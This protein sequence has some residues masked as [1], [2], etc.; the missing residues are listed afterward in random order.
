MVAMFHLETIGAAIFLTERGAE[1]Q[2]IMMETTA[3]EK[4]DHRILSVIDPGES[5]TYLMAHDAPTR[6]LL[7]AA[8][9]CRFHK[10]I[11]R[12]SEPKTH[13]EIRPILSKWP[14]LE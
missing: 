9:G 10:G 1:I 4:L 12:L 7:A 3:A 5:A 13:K 8:L 11:A 6:H 14:G 2:R